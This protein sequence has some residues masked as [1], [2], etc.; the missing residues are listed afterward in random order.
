MRRLTLQS[1]SLDLRL[2]CRGTLGLA[3]PYLLGQAL[4]QPELT[5]VGVA[6]FLLA[7]GDVAGGKGQLRR[8]LLGSVAGALA[9]ACGVL[10]GGHWA[11]AALGMALWGCAL[12]VVGVFGEAAA[13][14]ALPVAWAYLE[15]GLSATPHTLAHATWLAGWFALGGLWAMVLARLMGAMNPHGPLHRQVAHGFAL[16]T[17]Y[18]ES[19]AHGG[20]NPRNARAMAPETELR[21]AIAKA[22][23]LGS[24][25]RGRQQARAAESE[26]LVM[27]LAI[28]DR[29]FAL[30]AALK[31][32]EEEDRSTALRDGVP[33]REHLSAGARAIADV[34]SRRS[35]PVGLRRTQ[36]NLRAL[37]SSTGL[38]ASAPVGVAVSPGPA[39]QSDLA[40]LA[41]QLA[42]QLDHGLAIALGDTVPP[43]LTPAE[44]STSA[45]EGC[46]VRMRQLLGPLRLC[47]DRRSLV[48]R[49]ALRYGLVLG[50]AVAIDKGFALPFGYWIP[51]TASVVLRPYAGSTLQRA[52]QRLLGTATGIAAGMALMSLAATTAAKTALMLTAFFLCLAVL[53]ID[54]ALAIGF[55]S[56]GIVPFEALLAGARAPE[57]GVL[58]LLATLLG[59]ALALAG[60]FLLWPSFESR[61]LPARLSTALRAMATYADLVLALQASEA[62]DPKEL[63]AARQ[64]LG[65]AMTNVQA[66]L[67]RLLGELVRGP[68]DFAACLLATTALQRLFVS[69]TALRELPPAA[70]PAPALGPFRARMRAVLEDH[71]DRLATDGPAGPAAAVANAWA[72][73]AV[74]VVDGETLVG[75]ELERISLQL[76]ALQEATSRLVGGPGRAP[77]G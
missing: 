66:T 37:E 51:L 73:P 72:G 39:S 15:V 58:R 56:A 16:L 76:A 22:Q 42:L 68:L 27:L 21:M 10:A 75:Y 4:A 54:Y 5:G 52:G 13:A 35:D 14:M 41:G 33:H 77:L 62:V 34:L 61:G 26:K 49:H 9:V 1:D 31:E 30:A 40:A 45:P 71:A 19:A 11:L 48:G 6:A 69:L 36:L 17:T 70:A 67:Q 8:L 32:L 7:F 59:G 20:T 23:S 64:R 65:V 63:A 50:V 46:H 47:F 55:L 3:V 53:P 25:Q 28:A 29:S 2:A 74:A 18:L 44:P 43:T 57:V 24:A 12:G 60:G 38:D